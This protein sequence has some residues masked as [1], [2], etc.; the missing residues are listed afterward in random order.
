[1]LSF[2]MLLEKLSACMEQCQLSVLIY[3]YLSINIRYIYIYLFSALDSIGVIIG[4]ESV[5]GP[6]KNTMS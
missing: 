3:L 6:V 1:M 4:L 2:L 5:G